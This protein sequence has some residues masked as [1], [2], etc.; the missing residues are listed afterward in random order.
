M[1]EELVETWMKFLLFLRR[2]LAASCI[3]IGI[4]SIA[5]AAFGIIAGKFYNYTW[6]VVLYSCLIVFVKQKVS[7]WTFP[8]F[9]GGNEN[10]HLRQ[11]HVPVYP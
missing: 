1:D 4:S 6:A 7:P 2:H 9:M 5:A 11:R 3:V 10:L 8:P